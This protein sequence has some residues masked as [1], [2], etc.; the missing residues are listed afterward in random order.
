MVSKT[1]GLDEINVGYTD[2]HAG[3]NIRGLLVP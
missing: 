3:V 2:M 1:Y